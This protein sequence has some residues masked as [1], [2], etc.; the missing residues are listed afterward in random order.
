MAD[1]LELAIKTARVRVEALQAK[2]RELQQEADRAIIAMQVMCLHKDV[3]QVPYSES[4][5][6]PTLGVCRSCGL[7]VRNWN[8]SQLLGYTNKRI[9]HADAYAIMFGGEIDARTREGAEHTMRLRFYR[10]YGVD[11]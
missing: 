2:A 5:R 3:A 11:A 9:S 1:D 10:T 6:R 7:G 8:Q 4:D